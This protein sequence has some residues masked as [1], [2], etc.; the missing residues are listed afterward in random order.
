MRRDGTVIWSGGGRCGGRWPG[1]RAQQVVVAAGG[2]LG[3]VEGLILSRGGARE[4][5]GG[6]WL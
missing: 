3:L 2:G 1:R 6:S 5:R 4:A